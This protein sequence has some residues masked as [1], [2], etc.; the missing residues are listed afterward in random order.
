MICKQC[1]AQNS[2]DSRFC[3]ECGS[4][5]DTGGGGNPMPDGGVIPKRKVPTREI[6]ITLACIAAGFIVGSSLLVLNIKPKPEK[7]VENYYNALSGIDYTTLT[8]LMD[9]SR[10]D[11]DTAE[12]Q[13]DYIILKIAIF[14]FAEAETAVIEEIDVT[15]VPDEDEDEDTKLFQVEYL[16]TGRDKPS[17]N[18]VALIK[19]Q[20]VWK[21]LAD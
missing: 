7:V 10:S 16:M 2:D 21:V 13:R 12:K 4:P 8:N 18:K 5:E 15:E 9:F 20:D 6:W 19:T 11:A 17:S 1:G 3:A 14:R